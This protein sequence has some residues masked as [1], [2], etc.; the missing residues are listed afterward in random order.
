MLSQ[1]PQ[2]IPVG[3]LIRRHQTNQ[4]RPELTIRRSYISLPGETFFYS[5][6]SW[7]EASL[8]S[9]PILS[10]LV[11]GLYSPGFSSGI[12]PVQLSTWL[13]QDICCHR[14]WLPHET[15]SDLTSPP[16]D[17]GFITGSHHVRPFPTAS[18]MATECRGAVGSMA[19]STLDP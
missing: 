1:Q 2:R 6:F 16:P 12:F 14:H 19:Q 7:P 17:W 18:G 5:S 11:R 8:P 3:A 9:N 4:P 10:S 15:T 13:L